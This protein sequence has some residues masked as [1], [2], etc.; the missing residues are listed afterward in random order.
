MHDYES[1]FMSRK[2]IFLR[3]WVF[4]LFLL[5]VACGD[6]AKPEE[7]KVVFPE[8]FLWSPGQAVPS[9]FVKNGRYESPCLAVPPLM[10]SNGQTLGTTFYMKS[11]LIIEG[12]TIGRERLTYKDDRCSK[13]SKVEAYKAPVKTAWKAQ[14]DPT[15]GISHVVYT[16]DEVKPAKREVFLSRED[17]EFLNKH[18]ICHNNWI[19]ES[20]NDVLQINEE[21][22][23]KNIEEIQDNTGFLKSIANILLWK[24]TPAAG[25]LSL[26]FVVG[27][28]PK[29]LAVKTGSGIFPEPPATTV[30]VR[31]N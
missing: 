11:I 28:V 25:E 4:S 3:P 12:I 29:G 22:C 6:G 9:W 17:A 20:L 26:Y 10:M 14:K 30:F 7:P 27:E 19:A 18:G 13:I 23:K 21:S 31:V 15:T 8:S 1:E 5:P 2:N 16:T 24:L